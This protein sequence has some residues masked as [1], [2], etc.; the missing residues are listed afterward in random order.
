VWR[1]VTQSWLIQLLWHFFTGLELGRQPRSRRWPRCRH[2]AARTGGVAGVFAL[3]YGLIVARTAT[4]WSAAAVLLATATAGGWWLWRHRLRHLPVRWK[5]ARPLSRRLAPVLKAAPPRVQIEGDRTTTIWLPL[6]WVGTPRE[7]E[8]IDSIFGHTLALEAPV[9]DIQLEGHSRYVTYS[10]SEPPPGGTTW[11]D[12]AAAVADAAADEVIFGLGK[13]RAVVSASLATDS[14]HVGLNMGTGGGKTNTSS[15]GALQF[16][17]RGDIVAIIDAKLIS[18]PWAR[19]LPNICYAGTVPEIHDLLVALGA[20]LQRRN[21]VSLAGLQPSGAIDA[22]VGPRLILKAEELNFVIPKLK[23]HWADLRQQDKSLPKRSPALDALADIAFAGRQ[24][25][26]H[27]WFIGQMLTAAATGASDSSVRGNI[28]VACMARYRETT[29]RKM[30]DLPMPPPSEVP[31][32]IQVVT[33]AGIRETQVPYLA[34]TDDDRGRAA[35]A[36]QWAREYAT[37]G[38]RTPLPSWM[39]GA[40]IAPRVPAVAG[41]NGDA[42]QMP[43]DQPFVAG[44]L[45]VVPSTPG[46]VT[47]AEAVT[48]GMWPTQAAARKAVQRAQLEDAG[49]RGAAKLYTIEALATARRRKVDR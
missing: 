32:R 9:R 42:L 3:L 44:Q 25:R 26:M 24:V 6:D 16:L 19:G 37:G 36:A 4:T 43:P 11:A 17:H 48:A 10:K 30:S 27:I 18:Y 2:A 12:I 41:H 13:K 47:L 5:Y 21:E 29:W 1:K 49:Y 40:N 33:A 8:Q 20:E 38:V 7:W 14:P 45:P 31:G 15:L 22:D 35:A 46:A 34:L 28:G 39:P 23:R